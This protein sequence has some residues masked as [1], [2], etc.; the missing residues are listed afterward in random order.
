MAFD[1]YL[2][3]EGLDGESTSKGMEKQ[4]EIESFSRNP[5]SAPV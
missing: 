5:G 4:I 3:I 1:A 2:K